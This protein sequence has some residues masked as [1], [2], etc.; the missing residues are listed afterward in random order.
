MLLWETRALGIRI[1][2][3]LAAV[4][5]VAGCGGNGSGGEDSSSTATEPVSSATTVRDSS[6]REPALPKCRDAEIAKARTAGY[7]APSQTVKKGEKL[8]AVVRTNCGT[9]SVALDTKRFPTVVNSFVFLVAHDFYDG[10][11][12]DKAGAGKYLHGG[13]PPGRGIGPGYAVKSRIPSNFIYRHGV[14]AMEVPGEAG[15]E[16]AGSQFFVVLAKPWL[17]FT[18]VFPPLGT[19]KKGFDVLN[20]ISHFGLSAEYPSNVGVLGPVGKL[21][22][23]VVIE[24]IAIER[25]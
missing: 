15:Y 8:T 9:F 20:G 4:A 3:V 24:D 11:P 22:R 2:A 17:D 7:R 25:R 16:R 5:T 1:A 18:G 19:I 14:V 12:F 13:D 23:P 10:L 21:R 6:T